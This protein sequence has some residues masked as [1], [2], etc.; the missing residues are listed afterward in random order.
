MSLIWE[1]AKFV[2]FSMII[3]YVSKEILVKLLRKIAEILDLTPK[4][5][6]NIAGFATSMPELLTVFFSGA[7]GLISAGLYNIAS[8]NVINLIQYSFSIHFNKN[9]KELRN[10]AIMTQLVIVCITI[11]IP[12]AM[13]ALNLQASLTMIPIFIIIFF[14]FFHIRK[15]AYK[16]YKVPI[17]TETESKKIEE[18][19][20]WV[21]H[22]RKYAIITS[23][24]LLAVGVILFIIG[25]LLGSTLEALKIKFN[26]PEAIIGIILGFVTSIPELITFIEAQRHHSE[27]TNDM[28]GVIEATS[29]LFSSNM[30]NLCVIESIGIIAFYLLGG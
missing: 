3:V 9:G 24:E 1:I 12:I 6:G 18:E 21:R 28:Q 30:I 27:K 25:N 8:S 11:F 17:V 15:N 19:K 22:K 26:I 7:Q 14:L 2:I 4:A 20:K 23:L 5:V 13:I 10:K 29:N 16:L